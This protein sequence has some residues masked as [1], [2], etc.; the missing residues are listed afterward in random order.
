MWLLVGF[1]LLWA[2]KGVTAAALPSDAV[3]IGPA[4]ARLQECQAYWSRIRTLAARLTP[5]GRSR[6]T[7]AAN[8]TWVGPLYPPGKGGMGV[9]ETDPSV[10]LLEAGCT[11]VSRR[12]SG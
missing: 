9:E 5:H 4:Q 7:S 12:A 6:L 3:H 1:A 10:P 11:V 2:V 8:M